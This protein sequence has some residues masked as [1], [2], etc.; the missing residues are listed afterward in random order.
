MI[1]GL[2]MAIAFPSTV[3]AKEIFGELAGMSGVESTYISGRFAHNMKQWRSITGS[4]AIN[5]DKGFSALYIYQC[6]SQEAVQKAA[7]ILTEYKRSN[8]D[9]E[10]VLRTRESQG[11]YQIFER[12][13]SED[14][15]MQMIIWNNEAPNVCEIVVIEWKDGLKREVSFSEDEIMDDLPFQILSYIIEPSGMYILTN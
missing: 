5:L 12:F 1:I 11:V 15:L 14:R 7:K 10:E 9:L 2:I 3:N 6:Y 8:P 4:H 13:D